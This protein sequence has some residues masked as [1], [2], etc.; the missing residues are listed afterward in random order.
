[1]QIRR[2]DVVRAQLDPV[3]GSEQAGT[4]PAL[5]VS[6]DAINENAPVVIVAPIT[7]RKT[8]R[9]YPHEVLIDPPDGGLSM[10][11]KAMLIHIR[12]IDRT[13]VSSVHGKVGKET[14]AAL[15]QAVLIATGVLPI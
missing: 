12:A 7:S 14:L 13:R 8:D 9:V 11:S 15:D 2:G 6:P 10:R 4:R 1:M 3:V 5:V